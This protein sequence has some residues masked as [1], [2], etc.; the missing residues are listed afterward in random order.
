MEL[1]KV[2]YTNRE[3]G[4]ICVQYHPKNIKG[5]LIP[6]LDSH[7][8][9]DGMGDFIVNKFAPWHACGSDYASYSSGMKRHSNLQFVQILVQLAPG[10]KDIMSA[11]KQWEQLFGVEHASRDEL[12]FTNCRVRFVEG[13]NEK[14]EG[15]VGIVLAVGER[16][17]DIVEQAKKEGVWDERERCAMFL[18]IKWWFV[19]QEHIKSIL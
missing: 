6:E 19:K 17:D 4:S 8:P 16:F 13:C 3:E 7:S 2:I 15:L 18:G 1:A 5:G 9:Q 14:M 10:D 12:Q 11:V